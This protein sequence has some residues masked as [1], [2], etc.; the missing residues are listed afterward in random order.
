MLAPTQLNGLYHVAAEPIDKFRLLS[1]VA[2]QYGKSIE[3]RPDD[4]LVLHRSLEGSRFRAATGYVAPD[5]VEL[6]RRMH[7]QRG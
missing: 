7:E 6:V 2:A 1:L 5:W 3:I 4:A